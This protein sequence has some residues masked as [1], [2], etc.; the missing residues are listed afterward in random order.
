ML[1]PSRAS[2]GSQRRRSCLRASW[3]ACFPVAVLLVCVSSARHHASAH[4]PPPLT[5]AATALSDT[6]DFQQQQHRQ[7][8]HRSL[9]QPEAVDS[10]S[11]QPAGSDGSGSGS[12]HLLPLSGVISVIAGGAQQQ[13]QAP[14]AGSSVQPVSDATSGK[15]AASSGSLSGDPQ[16]PLRGAG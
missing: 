3:L 11:R 16:T 10:R 9:R 2:V 15:E 5:S 1:S 8:Q 4:P 12:S 14:Q 13:L 7:Q 6:A